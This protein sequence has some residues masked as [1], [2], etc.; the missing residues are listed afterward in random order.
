MSG[1]IHGGHWETK[2]FG[3]M[4]NL[5]TM[6]TVKRGTGNSVPAEPTA[7]LAWSVNGGGEEERLMWEEVN[8]GQNFHCNNFS[9]C[10]LCG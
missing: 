8:L 1:S 6:G 10:N 3:L 5:I 4:M 7:F 9:Q 2:S